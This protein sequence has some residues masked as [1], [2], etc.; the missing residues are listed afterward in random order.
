LDCNLF[1]VPHVSNGVKRD[2]AEFRELARTKALQMRRVAYLLCGDWHLAEDLVQT[3][4]AKLYRAWPKVG[5]KDTVDQLVR[6]VLLRCWIDESRRPWR[7]SEQRH[8]VVP[9]VV[10]HAADPALG[11]ESGN[12]ALV[13]ALRD[14]P[15][16]QRAVVVL[17][18]V[19]GLSV[20]EAA[21]AL[22]CS[23]GNVKSQASR[24]LEALRSA[25][26]AV[27]EGKL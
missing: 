15:P 3:A 21:V 2:D 25:L 14:L 13:R 6:T 12:D 22:K 7:R 17:R 23:E 19:E 9:D 26:D 27:K 16:R 8:A 18:Y 24:G 1:D 4:L 5:R 20:A 10:D 11:V